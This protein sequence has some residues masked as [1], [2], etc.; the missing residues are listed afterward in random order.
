MADPLDKVF[1]ERQCAL[2][3]PEGH[4][5]W[6]TQHVEDVAPQAWGAHLETKMNRNDRALSNREHA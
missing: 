1:G 6:F 5:W 2:Q 3:D 4:Y